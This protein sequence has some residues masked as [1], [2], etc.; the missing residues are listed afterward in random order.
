MT[1]NEMAA[2][3]GRTV[4]ALNEARKVE[5]CLRRR[6]RQAVN[7]IEEGLV[8]GSVKEVQIPGGVNPYD[9]LK[10]LF[11]IRGRIAEDERFMVEQGGGA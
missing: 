10:E 3:I 1:N 4:L 8:V 11:K 6:L 5:S 7:D 9:D 2:E